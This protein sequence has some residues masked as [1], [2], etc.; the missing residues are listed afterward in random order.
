MSLKFAAN[1][2]FMFLECPIITER[3]KLAKEAGF[4]AVE[5]GFP[6]GFSIQQV[7]EAKTRANIDQVLIN[8]FTGRIN[9]I[10]RM[11]NLL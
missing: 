7:V 6:F 9:K 3:Y 10:I 1:L 4:K 2:S 11:I 8:V 5:S